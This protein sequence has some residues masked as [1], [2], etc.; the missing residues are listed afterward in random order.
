V[1][2]TAG[3]VVELISTGNNLGMLPC[4]NS[5]TVVLSRD[6]FVAPADLWK[7]SLENWRTKATQPAVTQLTQ[8]NKDLLSPLWMAAGESFY[9]NHTDGTRIQGWLFKPYG[10]DSTKKYP[11]AQLIHGGPESAWLDDW[12]YRWNPQLWASRGY[13]TIAINPRG[14]TGFGQ[15]F[16]DAVQHQWGGVP[17]EDLMQG[18]DY[19]LKTYSWID[20]T[21]QTAC[22]ASYGGFMINWIN[23]HDNR[24]KSM[25]CHDGVFSSIGMYYSTDEIFFNE[26]EFGPPPYLSADNKAAYDKWNP[27]LFVDNWQTPT[28]VVQGGRD[29]R[30][31]EAEGIGAFTALQRLGIDSEFMYF[32]EENHWVLKQ[33]NSI[34]WYTEV[35]AWLDKYTGNVPPS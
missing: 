8:F 11:L 34:M 19:I 27:S 29:Y 35:L 18:N 9:F 20:S 16:T 7:F 31:P 30:I 14:S 32:P 3:T 5:D 25:V 6:L 28:L 23:G 33:Q 17:F 10:W 21:K 4:K 12:S 22:G 1:D 24:F 15:N 2:A 13:A 26:Y